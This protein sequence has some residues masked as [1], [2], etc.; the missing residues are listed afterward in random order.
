[1]VWGV[2]FSPDGSRLVTTCDDGAARVWDVARRA[3]LGQPLWHSRQTEGFYTLAL[4]PDGR[5]LLT[6][7]VDQHVVRWDVAQGKRVGSLALRSQVRALAFSRDGRVA[8]IG[9]EGGTVHVW[10]QDSL[11]I[12]DL[13]LQGG[14]VTSL[15]VSPD[16]ILF[17][18]GTGPGAVRFW[19]LHTLRPIGQTRKIG[20][21]VRALAFH[22]DGGTLAAGHDDGAIRLWEVLRPRAIGRPLRFPGPLHSLAVDRAGTRLLV[23]SSGGAQWF[24]L[25]PAADSAAAQQGVWA[26]PMGSLLINTRYEPERKVFRLEAWRHFNTL[27]MV[28]ATAA[29]PDGKTVATA[30]WA[31]IEGAAR[32]RVV[33]WDAATGERLRHV[34]DLP[35]PLS[36]VAYSPDSRRLLTWGGGPRSASLWDAGTLRQPRPVCRAL[37][38]AI[39]RA[40]FSTDGGTVLLGCQ[41]GTA[42]LWDLARDEEVNPG[43]RLRH[44]FPIT[45]VALE[46]ASR[47]GRVATGCS[48]GTLRLWDGASGALLRD[49]RGPGE[50]AAVVFAPDGKTLLTASH[51][52]TARFWDAGSGTQLGP[53]LR[54][55]DVVVGVAFHP[56]G[57]LAMTGTRDG[58]LQRWEVPA[59]PEEGSVEEIRRRIEQRTRMRLD[60]RGMVDMIRRE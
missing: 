10:Q 9:T 53:T 29:S 3:Q 58:Q 6:G 13:P 27:N 41:D 40:V 49:I 16:G 17:A 7:G 45:A 18:V 39:R 31:G 57:R 33:L 12:T 55:G 22:P 11:Q 34:S 5:T 37:G 25:S 4:S 1:M 60:E 36:G 46:P 26:R 23:G 47:N 51:D 14:D 59:A 52:G 15:A 8:L 32:G 43:H 56:D 30:G 28:E 24:D 54:H 50:I 21:R 48:A 20:A 44:G 19:D 35:A 42:R 38:P 2:A